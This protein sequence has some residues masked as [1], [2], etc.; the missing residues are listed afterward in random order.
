M[1]GGRAFPYI[2]TS[3][4]YCVQLKVWGART[5]K[6]ASQAAKVA[7]PAESPRLTLTLRRHRPRLSSTQVAGETPGPLLGCT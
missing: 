7:G 6:D 2:F 1:V 5:R 4:V 3:F